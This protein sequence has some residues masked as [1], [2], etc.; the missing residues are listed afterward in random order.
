MLRDHSAKVQNA[1]VLDWNDLRYFLAVARTGSTLA[2]GR[3]L[4]VS[5]TTV[6][7]R[8]VALEQALGLVL[9]ERKQSGYALTEA[10]QALLEKAHAVEA[11][12]ESFADG[13]AAG[14]RETTGTVRL[15]TLDIY[16]VTI[17]PPILRDLYAA[18]PSIR[19]ELDTTEETRD[20][21]AGAADIA[22]RASNSPTG[23]GL[24]GRRI[25]SDPWTIYCSRDYAT[26]HRKPHTAEDLR[27]HPFIG[28]G[29]EGVWRR[30]GAWLKQQKLEDA[31]VIHQASPTGLLAA[32]R[33]GSGLAV[34]PCFVADREADLVRCIEPI[35]GDPAG[36]WLITHERL[37]HV[38]RVRAVMDFL[39]DRLTRLARQ[40][41]DQR[42][43]QWA[44]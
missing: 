15:T 22:L 7:R 5:Q 17:L 20:L 11:A 6:A 3:S 9:F 32:V 29:G 8:I 40:P 1:S 33:A 16:A 37:R 34:L 26:Q 44:A 13:A 36:L 18:Y 42:P 28:G 21:A 12:A 30:Y 14:S 43:A 31:V 38:P 2:A 24:V 19:I 35:A 41:E 10:A 27:G 25:A 39:A 4:R 23:A